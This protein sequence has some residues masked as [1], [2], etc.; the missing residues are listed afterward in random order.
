L[1]LRDL[2]ALEGIALEWVANPVLLCA[3][4]KSLHK[5]VVDAFLDIDT[6]SCAATLAVVEEDTK[7]SPSAV[8][9]VISI[10]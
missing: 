10:E 5:L 3:G 4:L 2:W 7:V 1:E 9:R 8:S 6:G